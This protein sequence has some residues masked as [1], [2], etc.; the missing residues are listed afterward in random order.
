[1][2][3]SVK[4]GFLVGLRGS[5]GFQ[6]RQ[7]LE[8]RRVAEV[9]FFDCRMV[10]KRSIAIKD[11]ADTNFYPGI[12]PQHLKA[13]HMPTEQEKGIRP[14]ERKIRCSFANSRSQ[15][16]VLSG[17]A[18][19]SLK[20]MPI[21]F[22]VHF[23]GSSAFERKTFTSSRH[24]HPKRASSLARYAIMAIEPSGN[25]RGDGHS[26]WPSSAPRPLS[27]R[28]RLTICNQ[29]SPGNLHSLFLGA[30][31][32]WRLHPLSVAGL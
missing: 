12:A 3:E 25:R 9:T 8:K 1:L 5:A 18:S 26:K 30:A 32:A 24:M 6:W 2:L 29:A 20:L 4:V 22:I 11:Y 15:I 23:A 17:L 21:L 10:K 31:K 16:H 14:V 7:K 13:K 28:A 19:Q 27:G